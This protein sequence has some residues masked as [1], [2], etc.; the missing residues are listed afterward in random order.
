MSVV[1]PLSAL[2]GT[3]LVTRLYFLYGRETC[4]VAYS[5]H[6]MTHEKA[7]VLRLK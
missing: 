7:I 3:V 1:W 6:D 2:F 4:H 5:M